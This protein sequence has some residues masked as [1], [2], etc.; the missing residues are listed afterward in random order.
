MAN[1][2]ESGLTGTGA[3]DDLARFPYK[4]YCRDCGRDTTIITAYDDDTTELSY[5][6]TSCSFTASPT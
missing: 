4:P 5:T 3:T 2:D 6:C 1:D